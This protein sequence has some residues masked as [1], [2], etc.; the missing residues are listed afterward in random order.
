MWGGLFLWLTGLLKPSIQNDYNPI[1]R[2]LAKSIQPE[3]RNAKYQPKL[4]LNPDSMNWAIKH[5]VT[6]FLE[7]LSSATVNNSRIQSPSHHN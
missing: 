5:K 6:V 1:K 7:M 2:N 3:Q 4:A